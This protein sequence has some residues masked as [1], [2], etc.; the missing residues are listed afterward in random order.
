M[1]NRANIVLIGQKT[2]KRRL[3]NERIRPSDSG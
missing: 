2:Q 3:Q 1:S